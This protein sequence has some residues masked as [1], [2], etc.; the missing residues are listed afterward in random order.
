MYYCVWASEQY[1]LLPLSSPRSL[2]DPVQILAISKILTALVG[3]PLHPER[4]H[5]GLS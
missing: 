2:L 3:L 5:R 4:H 1:R